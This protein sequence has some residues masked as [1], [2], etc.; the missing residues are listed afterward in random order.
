MLRVNPIV[1]AGILAF[2][3]ALLPAQGDPGTAELNSFKLAGNIHVIQVHSTTGSVMNMAVSAGPDG[4]LL[5][6]HREADYGEKIS[7]A[8]KTI[9]TAPVKYVINTH[10]HLD[11]VG[12]NARYGPE[13]TII[14]SANARRK[15][16]TQTKVWWNPEPFE[17]LPPSGWPTVSLENSLTL[18]FN[19]EEIWLWHF[20][21]AHTD[22][23]LV[24]YFVKSRVVHMGDL[25]HGRGKY[26]FGEDVRGLARTL[27]EVARR[28]RPDVTIVTGHGK[29]SNRNEL[30][31]YQEI[32]ADAIVWVD[33]QIKAGNSLEAILQSPIPQRWKNWYEEGVQT[34]EEWI[35]NIYQSLKG[36][37]H[38]S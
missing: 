32:L 18:H 35:K 9:S 36:E 1:L 5:V 10:W 24:V 23:D 15:L 30:R 19:G 26:S 17:P 27:A 7:E 22:T 2:T 8:L 38:P 16:T 21:P 37:L 12:G 31:A 6:D 14:S 20:G 25:Y 3:P 13:A 4:I 11:H 28:V 34:P 29:L 33:A